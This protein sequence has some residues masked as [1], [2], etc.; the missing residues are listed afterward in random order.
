MIRTGWDPEQ[1]DESLIEVFALSPRK[2]PRSLLPIAIET[3]CSGTIR[4]FDPG[5]LSCEMIAEF[6][7]K[8]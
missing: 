3:G 7:G 6:R 5:S 1:E 8:W 2:L 4:V